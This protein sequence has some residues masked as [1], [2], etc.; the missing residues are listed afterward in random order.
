MSIVSI[1]VVFVLCWWFAFFLALPF[2]AKPRENPETG[3]AESAPAK[4]RIGLKALIAT[5]IGALMTAAIWQINQ[6][7]LISFRYQ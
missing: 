6:A 5:V 3:H 2:G 7:D 1:I 4:P